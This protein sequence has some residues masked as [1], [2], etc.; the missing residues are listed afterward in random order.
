[1]TSMILPSSE[2]HAKTQGIKDQL[3]LNKDPFHDG[4]F[5]I[6][7]HLLFIGNTADTMRITRM[8]ST[9]ILQFQSS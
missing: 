6:F 1:M 2:H 8:I 4:R 9:G 5:H 7:R 3:K